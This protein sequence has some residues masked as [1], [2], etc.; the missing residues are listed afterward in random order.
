MDFYEAKAPL[1]MAGVF[2]FV[3]IIAQLIYLNRRKSCT[4]QSVGVVTGYDMKVSYSD[5]NIEERSGMTYIYSPICRYEAG[6]NTVTS[7]GIY[8]FRRR[9]YNDGQSVTVFYDP[10]NEKKFYIKGEVPVSLF[11]FVMLVIG[12]GLLTVGIAAGLHLI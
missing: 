11:A 1:I 5:E 6:M 4:E 2:I 12:A 8:R 10:N 3:A 7:I 9:K